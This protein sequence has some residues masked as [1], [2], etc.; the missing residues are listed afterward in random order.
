MSV[1]RGKY[2]V[3]RAFSFEGR[4]ITNDSVHTLP[5]PEIEGRIVGGF[6]EHR[7][8]SLAAP[9]RKR[10]LYLGGVD[11]AS[12]SAAELAA[13]LGITAVEFAALAPSGATGFTVAD[14]RGLRPQE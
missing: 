11:F 3:R 9:P 10:A 13:T 2:R 8:G 12:D 5:E 4:Y 14:V 6:V 7:G 1:K